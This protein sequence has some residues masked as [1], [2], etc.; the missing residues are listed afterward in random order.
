MGNLPFP[1]ST[2]T[3]ALFLLPLSPTR[4]CPDL[5]HPL[6][7]DIDVMSVRHDEDLERVASNCNGGALLAL[8]CVYHGYVV[9]ISQSAIGAMTV[10]GE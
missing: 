1:V 9:L 8:R 6:I 5:L 10:R 2:V 4:G 7:G 3:T